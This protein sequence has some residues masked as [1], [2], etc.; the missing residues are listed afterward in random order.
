MEGL[1][2]PAEELG[3]CPEGG[4]DAVVEVGSIEE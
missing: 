4:G 3:F 2:G 1:D